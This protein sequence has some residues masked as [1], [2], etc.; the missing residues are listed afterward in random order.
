MAAAWFEGPYSLKKTA[1]CSFVPVVA[2]F[3][4][5]SCGAASAHSDVGRESPSPGTGPEK[6]IRNWVSCSGTS[7]DTAGAAKAI[8]AARRGAFTLVVDCPVNIKI[9]MDIARPIF[10][11]DGT[12]IEFT[13]SGKFKV[14]N[15]FIPAF[16]IADSSN[17]T[18]TNWNVEY[19]ASLPVDQNVGGFTNNG[20]FVKGP[21]PANAF[22]DMRLREW[23]AA[24]RGIVFDKSQG[25]VNPPW[26]GTTNPCAVMFITGDSSNIRVMG[27]RMYVPA[28]AGGERFIPVAFTVGVNFKSNQTVSAKTPMTGQFYAVPHD[29]KFSDIS[30]DGTYMGW[31]GGVQNAV[32]EN[33][34][35]QRYGDLQDANGGTIGGV[36]KWFAPPHLFYLSYAAAGDPGLF[37][38]NIEIKNVTDN[39]VRVGKARDAGGTDTLSG[40]AL[41]LK[42]GCVNCRVDHYVTA[43]PDGF[44]DVLPSDGLTVSNV[45]AT[46]DSSFLNNLFPGWRFPASPYKNVRFENIR[47]V[48]SAASSI[49]PPIGDAN[50]PANEGIVFKNIRVELNRWAG[51][52]SLPLPTIAGP[53]TDA[54]MDFSIAS[55]G[56]RVVRSRKGPVE[57]TFAAA[58]ATVRMG[59]PTVLTWTS[60]DARQCTAGGSWSGAVGTSGTRSVNVTGSGDH[61]FTL[62]CE[63]DSASAETKLRVAVSP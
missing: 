1:I 49:A 50:H 22:N 62:T 38:R 15:T 7:D 60:K 33:I 55:D 17:I 53:A 18:L 43:R 63:G 54:S 19:D 23:L 56:S 21:K 31:V 48:D 46:Y 32:F 41:S 26:T 58:P 6:S 10:I 27:M 12:A 51:R 2:L 29:V 37:N 42:I 45:T 44:L 35:S 11:E 16:V 25:S 39:G 59:A 20:E 52:A 8:A 28:D 34:Q 13:G 57:M 24:N 14:D 61:D 5:V 30:L 4:L 3:I 36:K 40:Y 47:L 9:G